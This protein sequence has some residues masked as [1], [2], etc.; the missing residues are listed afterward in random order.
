M[1]CYGFNGKNLIQ[2]IV[3]ESTTHAKHGTDLR[4]KALTQLSLLV[5]PNT[6]KTPG[7]WS[8]APHASFHH[9][10]IPSLLQYLC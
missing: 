10:I 1:R 4:P 3:Q 6:K 2:L 5:K 9:F 7:T 8:D